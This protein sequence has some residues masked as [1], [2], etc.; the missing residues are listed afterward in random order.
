MKYLRL[1]FYYL[2]SSDVATNPSLDAL[3][4]VIKELDSKSDKINFKEFNKYPVA[5]KLYADK[6]HLLDYVKSHKFKK[7]TFGYDLKKFWS[8][9]SVDLLKEYASRIKTKDAKRKRFT[10]LFWI[11]HDIIHFINGYNTT[12]L[13]EVA[14]LSFTL[15]KEKRTSFILFIIA[16][17][18][19][20]MKHGFMNAI[21]YPRICFE[22]YKRG[23][24]SKWFML[25]DWE[26]HLN[27]TTDDVKKILNLCDPPAFW[28]YFLKD[29]MR[30]H[31][32]LKE[33]AA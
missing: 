30:L 11:N 29:Y 27:K 15:A 12:P 10:D 25:M 19:V 6:Q 20:S 1:L 17:W 18:F 21:R 28:N 5:K 4:K 24:Y 31:N 16:G 9:Q 13:A 26:Q 32:Y 3:F 23:K 14:V 22:A 8:D 7:G 2:K 33:R